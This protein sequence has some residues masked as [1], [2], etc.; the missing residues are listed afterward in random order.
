[1]NQSCSVQQFYLYVSVQ[2]VTLDEDNW[3]KSFLEENHICHEQTSACERLF[4]KYDSSAATPMTFEEINQNSVEENNT[5]QKLKFVFHHKGRL[6]NMLYQYAALHEL[7]KFYDRELIINSE[8]AMTLKSIFIMK[9]TKTLQKY[10][11]TKIPSK[12]SIFQTIDFNLSFFTFHSDQDETPF[13]YFPRW[14][15]F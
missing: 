4:E 3:L 13:S 6:G 1:M 5:N 7:S 15:F 9:S 14:Q 2:A 10:V 11:T 8:L 12:R